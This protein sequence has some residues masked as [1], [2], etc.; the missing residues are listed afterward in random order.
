MNRAGDPRRRAIVRLLVAIPLC[1]MLVAGLLATAWLAL[2]RP[3]VA[4]GAVWFQL[5]KVGDSEYSGAPD[6]PFLVCA[7]T[8]S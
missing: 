6:Q 5:T 3:T 8:D 2:G 1:G 7:V 4:S